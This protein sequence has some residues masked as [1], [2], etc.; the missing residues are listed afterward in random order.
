MVF[1][2]IFVEREY[3]CLDHISAPRLVLDCG[4]NAGYASAYF[5][6]N[7]PTAF[8][9]AVEPDSD[10]FRVLEKNLLPYAGRYQ[11]VQAAVWP[12]KEKLQF[13]SSSSGFGKEWARSVE[14]ASSSSSDLI[15]TV[16][17]P[18]LIQLSCFERISILKV[19]IE[20]AERE[21]FS[22]G[23]NAWLDRVDNIVIELHNEC[24]REAFFKV[25]DPERFDISS[26]G[27]LTVCLGRN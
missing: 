20:G 6:S 5:L 2:Q 22:S 3:R 1:E 16:D 4:A 7:F 8:V 24:C 9:V 11:V 25:I 17:I 13:Q 19:D 23:S 14:R 27:E 18:R 12:H 10:N 26:C 15:E 21:L